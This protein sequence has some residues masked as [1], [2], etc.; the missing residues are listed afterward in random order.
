MAQEV[1]FR[2]I[3]D[4]QGAVGTLGQLKGEIIKAEQQLKKFRGEIN[5]QG[6]A[7]KKS[8]QQR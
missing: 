8:N 4:G 5:K 7:T 2:F 3:L 6:G 1:T